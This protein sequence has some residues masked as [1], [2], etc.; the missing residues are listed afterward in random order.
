MQIRKI[1][2]YV[3]SGVLIMG[4]FMPIVSVPIVGSVTYFKNGEGDGSV[5]LALG[6]ISLLV[7]AFNRIKLL[8][9]TGTL[10]LA[11][12]GYTFYLFQR[13]LSETRASIERDLA[14][15]PFAGLARG[16]MEG[17]QLQWGWALLVA[18]AALLIVASVIPPGVQRIKCFYCAELIRADAKVCKHCGREVST[19]QS[20]RAKPS[21]AE[22]AGSA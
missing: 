6:L 10:S 3:G 19:Y 12:L 2:G 20:D 14:G 7:L 16:F 15:N 11:V 5:V 9:I 1:L 4:V 22:I 17:A 18:G 21:D 8:A 13:R